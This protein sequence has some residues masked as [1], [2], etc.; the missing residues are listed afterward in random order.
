M[1]LRIP[2][3]VTVVITDAALSLFWIIR[4]AAG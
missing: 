2:A 1:G 4:F 3:A